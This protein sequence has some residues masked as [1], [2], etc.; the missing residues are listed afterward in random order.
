MFLHQH[1]NQY[2][3]KHGPKHNHPT[4]LHENL[5]FRY[6]MESYPSQSNTVI[7]TMADT[8]SRDGKFLPETR[9]CTVGFRDPRIMH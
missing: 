9:L 7:P 5:C 8:L 1:G 2:D 4:D 6:G 3:G